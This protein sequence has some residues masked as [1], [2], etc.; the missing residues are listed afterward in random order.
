MRWLARKELAFGGLGEA[1][2]LALLDYGH[3]ILWIHEP[4]W[5]PT[6]EHRHAT[7]CNLCSGGQDAFAKANTLPV[8][9]NDPIAGYQFSGFQ[10]TVVVLSF[11]LI[12]H[13][14]PTDSN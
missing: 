2:P 5:S 14:W 8:D 1:P 13:T 4:Q 12:T 3:V 7:R 9:T 6:P 10:G 11:T